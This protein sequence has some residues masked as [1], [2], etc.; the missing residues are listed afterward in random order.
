M[1]R[2]FWPP[3]N[4]CVNEFHLRKAAGGTSLAVQWLRLHFHCRRL[5]FN[6]DENYN[7]TS[8]GQ[9]KGTGIG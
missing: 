5:G 8:N 7:L 6:P 3:N 1:L 4:F 2:F 9:K